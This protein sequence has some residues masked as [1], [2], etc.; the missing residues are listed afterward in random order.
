[1]FPVMSSFLEDIAPW[2]ELICLLC[3]S[4]FSGCHFLIDPW[5]VEQHKSTG[6]CLWEFPSMTVLTSLWLGRRVKEEDA[7][8]ALQL[9][10]PLFNP[11]YLSVPPWYCCQSQ[12]GKSVVSSGGQESMNNIEK[13]TWR[14]LSP[15]SVLYAT[16]LGPSTGICFQLKPHCF[17]LLEVFVTAFVLVWQFY[18]KIRLEVYTHYLP[19]F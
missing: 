4:V 5:T 1:M 9:L 13:H 18:K 17:L 16:F 3:E 6:L 2:D 8:K 15:S 19:F 12:L 7:H 14:S 11:A 10:V